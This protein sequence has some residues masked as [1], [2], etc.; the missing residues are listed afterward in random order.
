MMALYRIWIR[1]V[2]CWGVLGACGGSTSDHDA[3]ADIGG[4]AF[5]DGDADSDADASL[6]AD[7]DARP[8]F[9]LEQVHR[10]A[11]LRGWNPH[12]AL[13]VAPD[14]TPHVAFG[15]TALWLASRTGGSWGV[16]IID[17]TPGVG[18]A[19]SLAF[20]ADGTPHVL[21]AGQGEQML[22]TWREGSA[23]QREVLLDGQ[24]PQGAVAIAAD[25][26]I[27]VCSSTPRDG[28][29]LHSSHEPGSWSETAVPG[30]G[31]TS[32]CTLAT[33]GTGVH[34][35]SI[36]GSVVAYS[37]CP[38]GSDCTTETVFDGGESYGGAPHSGALDIA[39]AADGTPH[40][41]FTTNHY[42]YDFGHAARTSGGWVVAERVTA[43]A[44]DSNVALAVDSAAQP[45]LFG[46]EWH[47]ISGG[48]FHGTNSTGDWL[49]EWVDGRMDVG[50]HASAVATTGGPYHLAYFSDA[51]NQ[52]L[53]A[54]GQPGAWG[55]PEL[56]TQGY[57]GCG[58]DLSL[59]CA[60]GQVAAA[61]RSTVPPLAWVL[62][63][64][65]GTLEPQVLGADGV[66][67]VDLVGNGAH[68]RVVLVTLS[69]FAVA[70]PGGDAWTVQAQPVDLPGNRVDAVLAPDG[71]LHVATAWDDIV[72]YASATGSAS[73]LVWSDREQPFRANAFAIGIDPAGRPC[74]TRSRSGTYYLDCRDPDGSW[75]E[76]TV[77]AGYSSDTLGVSELRTGPDGA[78]R[79]AYVVCH[80]GGECDVNLWR[81]ATGGAGSVSVG[82]ATAFGWTI[83]ADGSDLLAWADEDGGGLLVSRVVD[84]HASMVVAVPEITASSAVRLCLDDD[85]IAHVVLSDPRT[86][87]VA[88]AWG[89]L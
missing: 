9:S 40:I 30:T 12:R 51:E 41:S 13:A 8:P 25:G 1:F 16:S 6:D 50:W 17:D 86:A 2:C 81:Q 28:M 24:A 66:M 37:D 89:T 22:H 48:L 72:Y 87:G 33:Q 43:A 58:T 57:D 82:S 38:G 68:A 36:R 70:V 71:T 56:V 3:L 63:G 32:R 84:G 46:Y 4:D 45:H 42:G 7:A 85:S 52:V 60:D 5:A 76:Q 14:G 55:A 34:I 10:P 23:W 79:M 74:I 53:Y 61:Y 80:T 29:V 62:A 11:V 64:Q 44:P 18:G 31:G 75:P 59:T 83:A 49:T 20:A 88:H 35:V 77:F 73:S 26:T 78:L 47:G 15:Q 39:V 27:F 54:S 21:C 69:G 65:F 67:G 19:T